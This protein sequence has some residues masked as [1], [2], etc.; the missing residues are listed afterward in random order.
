[1]VEL[2]AAVELPVELVDDGSVAEALIV[3]ARMPPATAPAASS[4]TGLA[5]R[6]PGRPV[7]SVCSFLS[8]MT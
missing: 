4:P 1:V 3:A 7:G 2:V 5:S 8:Y 6:R